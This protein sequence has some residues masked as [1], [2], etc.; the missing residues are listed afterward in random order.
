MEAPAAAKEVGRQLEA[1]ARSLS[2]WQRL[3]VLAV[4][5][6]LLLAALIVGGGWI[7][8]LAVLVGIAV[9]LWDQAREAVKPLLDLGGTVL[10]LLFPAVVAAVVGIYLLP[11]PVQLALIPLVI[12]ATWFGL[13]R[14]W[15]GQSVDAV[16]AAVQW[17]TPRRALVHF[18]IAALVVA[19]IVA[20]VVAASDLSPH[21]LN[22][23]QHRAGAASTILAVAFIGWML[24]MLLRLVGFGNSLIRLL[25]ALVAIPLLYRGAT[26][27]GLIGGYDRL[28]GHWWAEP[29][30]LAAVLAGLLAIAVVA[31][32]V[33]MIVH[34]EVPEKGRF[35]SRWGLPDGLAATLSG[36]GF[37]IV[38]L[39]GIGI[40]IAALEGVREE[41]DYQRQGD[42]LPA[43]VAPGQP[44][45]GEWPKDIP[46]DPQNDLRLA[47]QYS[48]VL[49][50]TKGERWAPES[51][52]EYVRRAY[53]IR[54]N[55]KARTNLDPSKL[56]RY[57]CKPLD[58]P[59]CFTLTVSQVDKHGTVTDECSSGSLPCA[60]PITHREGRRYQ[61]AAYF[62]VL[63]LGRK[64]PDK[65]PNAFRDVGHYFRPGQQPS[66]LIQYWFFYPYDEWSR[67]VLTG[68]LTQRHEADWEA[69]TVGLSGT[70][71][72]FVAYSAHCGST[73]LAWGKTRAAADQD[74]DLH[75]LVAVA[76]GSH[77][78]YARAHDSRAPDW[79]AC[80]HG[81]EGVT[82]LIS[83]ASN[84]RDETGDAWTWTPSE[85]LPAD[86]RFEP[87]NFPGTWGLRDITNL[88]NQRSQPLGTPGPGPATPS[89]QDLWQNPLKKIFCHANSSVDTST[90]LGC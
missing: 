9:A 51:V 54:S 18:L 32:I 26:Y 27:A 10:P 71:P 52:D 25:I 70:G 63:R 23:V 72:I 58:K 21:D 79:A 38:L 8:F 41:A 33:E 78:N 37:V 42:A 3:C 85:L 6:L 39:A 31:Q 90:A 82:K 17:F 83:Y 89:L 7:F 86:Q 34:P 59:P 20:V 80:A 65:S 28:A 15:L 46:L 69:V 76:E 55:G 61:G 29:G 47:A 5:L 12:L 74:T 36:L 75:P 22:P 64:P 13:L 81:P 73:E 60:R 24:A 62:R 44:P 14:P 67:P 30:L 57:R 35:A 40:G 1:A 49:Q 4:G 43:G 16:V 48:P 50:M 66:T 84:I 87:M 2:W 53:L 77:A 45:P 56:G 88:K 11:A 19:V 68:Q